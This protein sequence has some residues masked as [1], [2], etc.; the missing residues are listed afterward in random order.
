M[1]IKPVCREDLDYIRHL[2]ELTFGVDGFSMDLL[3]K[4]INHNLLFI[5]MFNDYDE[6]IG[7]SI[8]IEG[9]KNQANIVNFLI[10]KG[11]HNQGLG[12]ILLKKTLEEIK[13]HNRFD[14]IV[15]NVEIKNN[16]AIH[17]YEKFNFIK[18]KK[19]DKYYESGASSYFM[20][21]KL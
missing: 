15:L 11:Y 3:E 6:I 12:S 2:E 5:K 18:I 21:L 1:I 17:L 7:I 14:S 16:A 13:K 4:L 9:V 8:C 10:K 20:K 19:I